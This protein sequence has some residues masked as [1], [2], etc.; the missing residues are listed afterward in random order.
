MLDY[1][2]IVRRCVNFCGIFYLQYDNVVNTLL[3]PE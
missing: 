1:S 2:D 3:Q